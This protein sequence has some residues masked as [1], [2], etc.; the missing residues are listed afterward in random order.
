MT[1]C[2]LALATKNVSLKYLLC[3][4]SPPDHIVQHS[5]ITGS[6]YHVHLSICTAVIVEVED[7]T[8][9]VVEE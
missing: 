8:C 6:I 3:A 7:R 4:N 9:K 5:V 2:P 1:A